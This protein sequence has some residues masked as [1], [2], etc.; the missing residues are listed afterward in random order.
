MTA[1]PGS[2]ASRPDAPRVSEL[3]SAIKSRDTWFP[4]IFSGPVANRLVGWIDRYEAIHPNHVTLI[5]MLVACSAAFCFA[6]G[7][8]AA[9]LAGALL[10][11]LAF[12]LDCADG[13]LARL[14]GQTSPFGG[15]LDRVLDRVK[16]VIYLGG[17]AL[18]AS[19]SAD[20]SVWAAAFLTAS[21]NLLVGFYHQQFELLCQ[22]SGLVRRAGP[23]RIPAAL[24]AL[25]LPFIRPWNSDHLVLISAFCFLDRVPLLLYALAVLTAVQVLG[26]PVYY[27]I[28]LARDYG[29]W[30]WEIRDS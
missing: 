20:S 19:R 3:R 15:V 29:K 24:R 27:A 22:S 6:L 26:R 16:L 4:T 7:S 23:T 11:H 1:P 13:Q 30:P 5:G 2:A 12:M 9:I 25:D 10:I 14:R 28:V 21:G 17:L 8:Y 18:G